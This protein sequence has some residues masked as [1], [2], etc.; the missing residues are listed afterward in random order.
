MRLDHLLAES[1][2]KDLH[3]VIKELK[4]QGWDVTYN[5]GSGHFKCIPPP[6]SPPDSNGR[7]Q[8]IYTSST[9]SVYRGL[10]NFIARCRKADPNFVWKGR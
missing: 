1:L 5:K 10:Q 7:P 9:P 4:K 6:G 2:K 3:K 8:I